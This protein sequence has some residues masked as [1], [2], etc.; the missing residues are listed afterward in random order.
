MRI[1]DFKIGPRLFAGFGIVLALMAFVWYSG[2]SSI[3]C[4]AVCHDS[5]RGMLFAASLH[6]CS[7]SS[8]ANGPSESLAYC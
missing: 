5:T 7:I 3:G 6:R 4:G 8:A 2:M 1:K